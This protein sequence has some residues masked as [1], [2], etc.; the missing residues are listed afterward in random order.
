[1]AVRKTARMAQSALTASAL[2]LMVTLSSARAA[3]PALVAFGACR[4]G[5]PNG[6]YELRMPDGGVRAVGAFHEG[7][8]TGTFFFWSADGGRLAA[9]PYDNDVRNGTIALWHQRGKPAH[10]AGRKLEAPVVAGRPHGVRRSWYE[11]GGLRAEASFDRGGLVEA[12]VW[13]RSG[14]PLATADAKRM[15]LQDAHGEE[16]YIAALERIVA[17]H[18]PQCE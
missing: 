2:L 12:Q 8:R 13:T 3:E 9:I 14:H 10:E 6:P 1:M 5:L 11:T 15:A 17:R 7:K 16:T 4:D 18:R